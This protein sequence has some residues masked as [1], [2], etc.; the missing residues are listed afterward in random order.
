MPVILSRSTQP[1]APRPASSSLRDQV[2]SVGFVPATGE[3]LQ[4]GHGWR[5]ELPGRY[6]VLI[7]PCP[8]VTRRPRGLQTREATSRGPK[9]LRGGC[10]AGLWAAR[11]RLKRCLDSLRQVFSV[12]SQFCNCRSHRCCW[13]FSEALSL[14]ALPGFQLRQDYL[15]YLFKMQRGDPCG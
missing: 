11:G 3:A 13:P 4:I 9:C 10:A 12:N 5:S 6:S 1:S 8:D 7:L 2:Y 15:F 14:H